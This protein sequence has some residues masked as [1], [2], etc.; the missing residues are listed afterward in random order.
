LEDERRKMHIVKSSLGSNNVN[1]YHGL[2]TF[3]LAPTRHQPTITM[4]HT[5]INNNLVNKK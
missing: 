3:L 1:V 5:K 4:K 2:G